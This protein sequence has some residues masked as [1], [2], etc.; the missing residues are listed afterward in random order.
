MYKNYIKLNYLLNRLQWE[1]YVD[2]QNHDLNETCDKIFECIDNMR[3]NKEI[4]FSD[5]YIR[6]WIDKSKEVYFLRNKLDNFDNY[7]DKEIITKEELAERI[8][9]DVINLM[10]L[11][12]K[13]SLEI[14]FKGYMDAIIKSDNM[15]YEMLTGWLNDYL[16]KNLE[17]A[18]QIIKKYNIKWKSWFSD[19][20]KINNSEM[21][22]IDP[23][24]MLYR[25]AEK[26]DMLEVINNIKIYYKNNICF[27]TMLGSDDIRISMSDINCLDDVRTLFHEFGHAIVY[28]YLSKNSS[29][30]YFQITPCL[31][32]VFAVIIENI[33]PI[34]VLSESEIE[35]IDEIN[36]LEYT[37]TALSALFELELWN[38]INMA[39]NLYEKYYAKLNLEIENPK[40][41]CLDSFR[42][43]D[44][45]YIHNYTLGQI[46]SEHFKDIFYNK[47]ER[48]DKVI[49]KLTASSCTNASCFFTKSEHEYK[50]DCECKSY[51]MMLKRLCSEINNVNY[52]DILNYV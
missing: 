41:W 23:Y 20:D 26:M 52:I 18:N 22:S 34:V 27:A 12:D 31:D 17:R 24:K 47:L 33:A 29:D 6:E 21:Q 5:R 3:R 46:A 4:I 13:K 48:N 40:L 49:E 44:C 42:S 8:Y 7:I 14:G 2:N 11:R 10:K 32:E 16:D 45:M 15:T 43:I 1:N 38:N 30:L 28:Y 36:C 25:F 19:L 51:G 35:K 9:I 37:R 50:Y 39:E